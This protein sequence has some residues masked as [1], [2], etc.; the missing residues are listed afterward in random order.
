MKCRDC[1][2]TDD[3]PRDG[4][5]H[6]APSELRGTGRPAYVSRPREPRG[7]DDV[8]SR[9]RSIERKLDNILELLDA[10]DIE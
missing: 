6:F 8:E 9:L 7:G 4:R 1:F 10:D 2:R 5:S 3:S